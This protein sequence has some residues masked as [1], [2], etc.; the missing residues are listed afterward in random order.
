VQ[1]TID[2]TN[3]RDQVKLLSKLSSLLEEAAKV[4]D[5]ISGARITNKQANLPLGEVGNGN[6]HTSNGSHRFIAGSRKA[7]LDL[8]HS[9][10]KEAGKPLHQADI[11]AQMMQTGSTLTKGNTVAVYLKADK[12][13]EKDQRRGFWKLSGRSPE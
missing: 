6:G 12:R 9:I 7:N 2:S 10:L 1:L 4:C 13:F 11:L 8:A 5:Q 3:L